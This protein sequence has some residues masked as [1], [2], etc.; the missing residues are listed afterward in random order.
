MNGAGPNITSATISITDA[1][2][3]VAGDTLAF[4]SQFGINGTYDGTT[5]V[6]ALSGPATASQYAT[7]LDS[8]TY[9]FTGDPTL[10]GTEHIRTVTYTVT[11]AISASSTSPTS[12]IDTFALPVVSV[13]AAPAPY[14]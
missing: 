9:S 1:G 5:G 2:T 8:L 12:T 3:V 13:G 7:V 4:T 10:A 14:P 6:L 11:D